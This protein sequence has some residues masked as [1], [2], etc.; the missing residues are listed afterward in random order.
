MIETVARL[1]QSIDLSFTFLTGLPPHQT[2]SLLQ[3]LLV[4]TSDPEHTSRKNEDAEPTANHGNCRAGWLAGVKP[5][6]RFFFHY[7]RATSLFT[8]LLLFLLTSPGG[9]FP[10]H[11]IKI[12]T[13][14]LF[15]LWYN[16]FCCRM[17]KRGA[18]QD[19]VVNS[20]LNG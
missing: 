5:T 9:T 3:L 15:L 6:Q 20:K 16:F 8:L 1:N 19:S 17:G 14:L 13:Q 12:C 4:G 7:S 11:L 10:I 18:G 2:K